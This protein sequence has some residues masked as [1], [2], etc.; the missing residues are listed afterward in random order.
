MKTNVGVFFGGRSVEHE[1]SVISALQAIN[2]FDSDKYNIIPIYITK[3]GRWYTGDALLEMNNYKDMNALTEKVTEVFMRPEY[4]DYNLYSAKASGLFS[5]KAP[6]VAELHVVIPVLHGTNGEDGIFEGLLETIGIPFAGCNTLSSANGMDKITMK[7]ILRECGVPVVDYVWFTDKE[8]G[9]DRD[10]IVKRVEDKLTYPVIVKPGNLG[11]SVGIG[12]ASSREE[13]IRAIDN[14]EQFTTR[15]I[16]EHMVE[17]L[18]EINC[19]VLGEADDC[20]ASVCEEPI[21]SGDFL[22]YEDKYMGGT[23]TTQGMQASEKRIPAQLTDEMTKRIQDM[24]RDTFRVLSCHG[25]SRIDVMVDEADDS[26]YVNE[27]NTI[28]GSLSFYLWEATGI[29]FTELMDRLVSLALKRKRESERKTFT[30]DHNIFA[31]G[32]GIKGAKGAK[33][34]KRAH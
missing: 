5:K 24:A 20:I 22:S 30:Y 8:W 7:M 18:K 4:G 6:V 23:K 19:S 12:K 3:K 9:R 27:I 10:A 14:A 28:P 32:G 1:I 29:S 31:L 25:V 2:A 15:I 13:L 26:V 34:T 33:G 11:S 17:K 16:V 21:K